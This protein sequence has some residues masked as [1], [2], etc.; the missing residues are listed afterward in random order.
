[1][2][3]AMQRIA[4]YKVRIETGRQQPFGKEADAELHFLQGP[5]SGLKLIGFAIWE[6]RGGS[7]YNVTVPSRSYAVNGD[8]RTFA[9]L[10]PSEWKDS[11]DP[12][13]TLRGMI[14]DAWTRAQATHARHEPSTWTYDQDGA[15]ILETAPK[16]TAQATAPAVTV[17]PSAQAILQS[18]ADDLAK[19]EV[20]SLTRAEQTPTLPGWTSIDTSTDDDPGRA[21]QP[22]APAPAPR[23]I[24]ILETNPQEAIEQVAA[25]TFT[26]LGASEK[27]LIRGGIFPHAAITAA[28]ARIPD[29]AEARRA[30]SLALMKLADAE[31]RPQAP[32]PRSVPGVRGKRT[33]RF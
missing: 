2:K 6:R 12:Q 31:P 17:S 30:L 29:T 23:V 11:V 21:P 7:G 1:M 10:R 14:L 33:S 5:L 18:I 3:D 19:G 32:A 27:A 20:P 15:A 22:Q 25:Q 9:L 28:E 26:T 16:Q 13:E 4:S 8:R 24:G